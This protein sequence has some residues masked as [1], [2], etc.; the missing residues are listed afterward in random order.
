MTNFQIR[1]FLKIAFIIFV[2]ITVTCGVFYF[3]ADKEIVNSMGQFHITAE[4]FLDYLLPAILTSGILGFIAAM[5]IA[6]FLPHSYGGPLYRIERDL[7]RI[8]DGDMTIRFR[9][10]KGDELKVLAESLNIMLEKISSNVREM[11]SVSIKCSQLVNEHE[12]D[13]LK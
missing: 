10:R 3:Y 11:K 4:N 8:G 1:L 7:K 13:K 6:I 2:S 9:L 5:V 12:K